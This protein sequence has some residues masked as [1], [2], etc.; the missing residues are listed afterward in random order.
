MKKKKSEKQ[1]AE[2]ALKKRA[3]GYRTTEVVEEYGVGE[4]GGVL[5]TKRRV[6]EKDVPPDLSALKLYLDYTEDGDNLSSMSL[7]E[8]MQ[9]REKLLKELALCEQKGEKNGTSKVRKKT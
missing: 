2:S 5:L 8:L 7:E 6:T 1:E 4:D 9:E 3:L